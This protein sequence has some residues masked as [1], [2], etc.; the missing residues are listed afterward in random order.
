MAVRKFLAHR[1]GEDAKGRCG[2]M[3]CGSTKI[4][5]LRRWRTCRAKGFFPAADQHGWTRIKNADE[6]FNAHY[7]YIAKARQNQPPARTVAP[8]HPVHACASGRKAR[9]IASR[10]DIIL[11]PQVRPRLRDAMLR[12]RSVSTRAANRCLRLQIRQD[13]GWER[14]CKIL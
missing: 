11:R 4:S 8:F 7:L 6:F 9:T 5:R 2:L 1:M 14:D 3:I 13:A 12:R 10:L